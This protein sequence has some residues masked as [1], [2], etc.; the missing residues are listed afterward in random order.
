MK[1]IYKFPEKDLILNG[2]GYSLLTNGFGSFFSVNKD[3][4]YQ[5]WCQLETND[6]SLRKSIESISPL[7][8]GPEIKQFNQFYSSRREFSTGAQDTIIP[9]QK[10]LLYSTHKLN[11]RVLLS[12]DHREVYELSRLNRIYDIKVE[13]NF[14]LVHFKQLKED[15]SIEYENFIGIKGIRSVELLKNWKEKHYSFDEERKMNSIYWIF[16]ALTFIPTHHVVFSSGKS[17]HEARTLADIA[18]FHFDDI[19]SNLHEKSLSN[20]IPFKE[21]PSFYLK[22]AARCASWSLNSLVQKFSFQHR[23]F[24]GI[25]AGLPWF[26]QIWSRDELISLGGLISLIEENNEYSSLIKTILSRHMKSIL[27]NGKVPNRYPKS[28]LDSVDA[29]GWLAKRTVDF[30]KIIKKNKKLYTLCSLD[31]L[32]SWF[33]IFKKALFNAKKSYGVEIENAVLFSNL[34]NETWMDTSYEDNG[35]K[36]LRVEIQGLFYAIYDVIILLGKLT[37]SKEVFRYRKEQS[38][39]KKA[40]RKK[41]LHDDFEG[42]LIDGFDKEMVNRSFRPNVFLTAYVA[43]GLLS[44]REWKRVF[45]KYLEKLFLPWGGIAT[46]SP[47]DSR[48]QSKHTGQDNKSYHRGDSWY[49]VNNITALVL[50]DIDE[51]KYKSFINKILNASSKDILECG[52][53][54]HASELSSA[55]VQESNGSLVQT[56][57][58]ST[59]IELITN[60]YPNDD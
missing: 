4:S 7:D 52:F 3:L 14:V 18:Y 1:N 48:F 36:G 32:I 20:F 22:S 49:F 58:A 26:F 28:E 9:Y 37:D 50:F 25:Y 24:P 51:E 27:P 60:L 31:E 47:D 44:S 57:S 55:M 39:F 11:G 17:E 2:K 34:K 29:L 5:G 42:F 6:W 33:E 41:F 23:M 53:S 54:G 46:I 12:L 38:L 35:R 15:G 19:V 59:F 40:F 16:E 13:Q 30:I 56:W 45:D 8:E 10:V 21:V 43:K